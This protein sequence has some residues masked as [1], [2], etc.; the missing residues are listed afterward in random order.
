MPILR[1]ISANSNTF[2]SD[3]ITFVGSMGSLELTLAVWY[4]LGF[5]KLSF[6]KIGDVQNFGTNL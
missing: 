3:E 6:I 1:H 5:L 2:W 4:N